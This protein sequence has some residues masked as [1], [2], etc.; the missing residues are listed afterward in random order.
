MCKNINTLPSYPLPMASC[1]FL[2]NLTWLISVLLS[3]ASPRFPPSLTPLSLLPANCCWVYDVLDLE[4]Q[5]LTVMLEKKTWTYKKVLWLKM[6][7]YMMKRQENSI[8]KVQLAFSG[9]RDP[10]RTGVFEDG[11]LKNISFN[12]LLHNN[13]PKM[14]WLKKSNNFLFVFM[15]SSGLGSAVFCFTWCLWVMECAKR[16]LCSNAWH[17]ILMDRTGGSWLGIFLHEVSPLE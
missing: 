11:F 3:L 8:Q 16:L 4:S 9:N 2:F 6:I 14:W 13:H 5:T 7:R 10:Y 1:S 17:L 12:L 15:V